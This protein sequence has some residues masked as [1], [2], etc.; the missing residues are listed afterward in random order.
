M[1]SVRMYSFV[2]GAVVIAMLA[3]GPVLAED[4]PPP[5]PP[6]TPSVS[7]YVESVPRGTGSATPR[8]I[9]RQTTTLTPAVAARLRNS[10]GAYAK[11]LRSI[12]TSPAYGA[13]TTEFTRPSAHDSSATARSGT[14]N[15]N[16]LS[17]A[18]SAVGDSG[19]SHIFWLL[20]LI[21]AVT[22]TMV[23]AAAGR[24]RA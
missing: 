18:V 14:E 2:A 10:E 3:A 1:G 24:D 6:S 9:R 23:L 5:T 22:A 12:A 21:V 15:G 7:Q 16:A 13:P 20:G 19:D 11:R 8:K 4:P 17:A